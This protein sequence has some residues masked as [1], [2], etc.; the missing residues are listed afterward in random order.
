MSFAVRGSAAAS[1]MAIGWP[2]HRDMARD[3]VADRD[4][5]L[6]HLLGLTADRDLE[7]EL[8]GVLVDQQ[9]RA[10]ACAEH[11]RGGLDDHLQEVGVRDPGA[12]RSRSLREAERL[13]EARGKAYVVVVASGAL[14]SRDELTA[15]ARPGT[16][17]G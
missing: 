17:G 16:S 10:R 7:H 14:H 8:L 11:L 3:P 5:K 2:G 12:D 1:E 15:S 9:Q 13:S 4:A 6:L